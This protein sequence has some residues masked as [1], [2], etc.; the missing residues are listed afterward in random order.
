VLIKMQFPYNNFCRVNLY[1]HFRR[2]RVPNWIS[3][4]EFQAKYRELAISLLGIYLKKRKG[5]LLIKLCS[6]IGIERIENV[7]DLKNHVSK[8]QVWYWTAL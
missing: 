4:E 7:F 1:S 8:K 6:R 2:I 3:N 5:E